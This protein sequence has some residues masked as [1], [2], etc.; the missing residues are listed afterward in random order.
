[1][2][3]RTRFSSG[4]SNLDSLLKGLFIGDNVV[5]YDDSGNLAS[6]FCLSFLRNALASNL[7]V[8]YVSFD[9]SPKNLLDKLGSLSESQNLWILDGF[10]CGKGKCSSVFMKYYDEPN[11]NNAYNI[12]LIKKPPPA[13]TRQRSSL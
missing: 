7:P 5:W 4:V 6:P 13:G 8:I 1:M 12:A 10:T 2:T 9:R 11:K 3:G